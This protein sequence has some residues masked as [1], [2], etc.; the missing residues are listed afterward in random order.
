MPDFTPEEWGHPGDPAKPVVASG[1]PRG[2]AGFIIPHQ[3]TFQGL[4]NIGS[5]SYLSQF[6]QAMAHSRVNAE[7]MRLDPV[8]DACMRLRVIPTSLLTEH[9][10]PD[11]DTDPFQVEC[12]AHS[13]RL[14][15]KLP[16]MLYVKRWML[17][18]GEFVGR[19]GVQVKYEFVNKRGRNWHLPAGFKMV[20]GDKLV[21][22]WADERIG[23]RVGGGFNLPTIVTDWGPA[24]MLSP[25]ERE[26]LI[27]HQYEP[28]DVSYYNN[29]M[30]GAIHGTGYRGRLYWLW[31]LKQRI[32]AMSTDFLQWFAK[33]LTVYYFDSG[34]DEHMQQIKAFAENQDGNTALIWPRFRDGG[35]GY[36]PIERFEASTASPQFLQELIT[37]Y[38]DDLFKMSILGQTLTSG[39]AGTGL[40]SGVAT[41]HQQTFDNFV[42][43]DAVGLGETLTRDLLA[44][45]Y[46]ANFPGVPCGRW[47]LDIDDPNAQQQIENAQALYQMGAAIPEGAIMAAAG[48]AE[49]KDGDTILT[50]VQPMQ[51]AAVGGVPDGVPMAQPGQPDPNAPPVRMSL[52]QWSEAICLARKGDRRAQ[53]LFRTR[54]VEVAGLS[55]SYTSRW[56]KRPR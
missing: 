13:E 30:A 7:L 42:K 34:N 43:Y 16:G 45:F 8:I 35:P 36:K 2:N 11:D 3:S 56:V 50:N 54:R 10:E 37:N 44:P 9:M 29:R 28:E 39:T 18:E 4:A 26:Q 32:W 19:A 46:R 23:I 38:F 51:P 41:A 33:G 21:F 22:P 49:V 53:K 55:P 20:G 6:D 47:V 24:Y 25:E 1:Q 15:P 52:R 40:G 14:L 31:A 48:I 12:A 17:Y 27:V 5:R